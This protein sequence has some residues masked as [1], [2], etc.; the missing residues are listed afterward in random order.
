M[1]IMLRDFNRGDGRCRV[2]ILHSLP[3]LMLTFPYNDGQHFLFLYRELGLLSA[4]SESNKKVT[5]SV[6]DVVVE[7]KPAFGSRYYGYYL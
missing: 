6:Q 5:S 3:L 4:M 2:V 7:K 1:R